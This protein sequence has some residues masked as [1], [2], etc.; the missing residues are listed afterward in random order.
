[1]T[2]TV[3]HEVATTNQ[4][5]SGQTITSGSFTPTANSNCYVWAV[6]ENNNHA[7]AKSWQITN[8]GSLSFSTVENPPNRSWNGDA[9]FGVE[10][11]LWVASVGGSPGAMT[12]TIDPWSGGNQSGFISLDVFCV[13]SSGTLSVVQTKSASE[14]D[15]G[16]NSE[17]IA[18]TM[19]AALTSGNTV[20][21]CGAASNDAAGGFTTPTGFSNELVNQTTSSTHV[22]VWH[23]TDISG[24][25]VTISDLGQS[26]GAS[27]IAVLE[28]SDGAGTASPAA[29]AVTT[30]IPQATATTS[31]PFVTQV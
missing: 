22:A 12:V 26:V 31:N 6:V 24:S 8:T 17:S 9:N 16:G 11:H 23:D 13:S 1:V 27:A 20:V 19:D 7:V 15:G 2:V 28:F 25:T 18:V 4:T 10:A 14:Q 29:I 3:D 5:S 21:C 30:S